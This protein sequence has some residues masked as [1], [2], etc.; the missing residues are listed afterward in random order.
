MK[1]GST[2]ISKRCVFV[3]AGKTDQVLNLMTRINTATITS[4]RGTSPKSTINSL[5]RSKRNRGRV[6]LLKAKEL[7]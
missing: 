4:K 2:L 7:S 3:R 6:V 5:M 1:R